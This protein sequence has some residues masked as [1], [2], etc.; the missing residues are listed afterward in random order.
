MIFGQGFYALRCLR[1]AVAPTE[2][3]AHDKCRQ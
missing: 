2:H 1:I 3:N